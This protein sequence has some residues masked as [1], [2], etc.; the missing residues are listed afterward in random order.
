[1]RIIIGSDQGGVHLKTELIEYLEKKDHVVRNMGTDSEN[2]VDYPDIAALTCSEFKRGDYDFGILICGTG[3]GVT[4][5]ANKIKGIRCAALT[6][7]YSARMA[8]AHNM[9]NF[10]AF[11]GRMIYRVPVS[12]MVEAFITTTFEGG[13][14][15]QRV[16]KVMTLESG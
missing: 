1:M 7:D 6:D 10:I 12:E 14:H 4:M 2:P 8:R 13:R 16:D 3:I 9:A 15:K 5:A 11:G